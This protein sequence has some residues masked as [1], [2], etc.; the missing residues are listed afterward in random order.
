MSNPAESHPADGDD[1]HSVPPPYRPTEIEP[2]WQDHW[3][4]AGTYQVENDDPRPHYYVLSMY[5]YPSGKA[6]MG[7]VRNYTF[8]DL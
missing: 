4:D 3:R 6:H 7:H 5:P 2:A 1:E 8:G